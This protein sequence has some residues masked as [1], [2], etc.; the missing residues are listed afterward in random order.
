MKNNEKNQEQRMAFIDFWANYV[1]THDDKEWSR[2]QNIII[3]QTPGMTAEQFLEM[4]GHNTK[5]K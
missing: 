5:V 2:L 1:R 3:N 4:K